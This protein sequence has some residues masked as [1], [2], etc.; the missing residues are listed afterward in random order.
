MSRIW[1]STRAGVAAALRREPKIEHS[2]LDDRGRVFT[3][4]KFREMFAGRALLRKWYE[5]YMSLPLGSRL[6]FAIVVPNMLLLLVV[7][8]RFAPLWWL[9][10]L[11]CIMIGS[12]PQTW[13][14]VVRKHGQPIAAKLASQGLCGACGYALKGIAAEVD[15]CTVC[16]ECDAAWNIT[17]VAAKGSPWRRDAFGRYWR[18]VGAGMEQAKSPVLVADDRG[19]KVPLALRYSDELA[20][21]S[22]FLR[23]TWNTSL[24]RTKFIAAGLGAVA[25]VVL[26]KL[27]G[28]VFVGLVDSIYADYWRL[29][30]LIAMIGIG[31]IVWLCHGLCLRQAQQRADRMAS[32]GVC[33]SCTAE[34][35]GIEPQEDGCRVC[36]DCGSAWR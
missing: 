18:G 9:L 13:N 8:F 16:P 27:L 15:G 17:S 14:F 10:V 2:I 24:L 20:A 21:A 11:V 29:G 28:M 1:R 23:K 5:I 35:K 6:Q 25:A 30:A 31:L 19:A 3:L 34:L 12:V 36:A 32:K 4:V 22:F 7:S 33:P 26:A